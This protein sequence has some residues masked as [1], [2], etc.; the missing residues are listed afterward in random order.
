MQPGYYTDIPNADYHVGPGVSK[1]I[2]DYVAVAPALA[3]WNRDCPRDDDSD[4]PASF[5]T[6]FH[7]F[8]LEP[9]RFSRECVTEPKLDRRTNVGKAAAETFYAE[10]AGKQIISAEDMRKLEFMRGSVM[11]HP[12]ARFLVEAQGDVEASIYWNDESTG[13]LCR[14]RMDKHLREHVI[15]VDVKTVDRLERFQR[16]IEDYR[17]FVQDGTYSIGYESHFGETPG[18]LF[19]VVQTTKELGRYPCMIYELTPEDKASGRAEFRKA[20]DTYHACKEAK[21]FPGVVSISRPYYKR[22]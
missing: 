1:S 9:D 4:S 21:E 2:L 16:A 14:M 7:T 10:H 3:E 18:F 11:A 8:L 6:L 22:T 17:Y 15:I 5:G 12:Q 20:L 19:L 13:E